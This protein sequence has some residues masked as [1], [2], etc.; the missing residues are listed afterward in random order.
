MLRFSSPPTPASDHISHQAVPRQADR[1]VCS[2]M[3]LANGYTIPGN[4]R[5]AA[6]G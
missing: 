5:Q 3:P 1:R 2:N 4:K 6:G